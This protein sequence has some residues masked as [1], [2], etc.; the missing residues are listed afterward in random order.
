MISVKKFISWQRGIKTPYEKVSRGY[1]F[2]NCSEIKGAYQGYEK[3]KNGN[4][5]YLIE[6]R[7]RGWIGINERPE[8]RNKRETLEIGKEYY[9]QFKDGIVHITAEKAAEQS[10]KQTKFVKEDKPF[11]LSLLQIIHTSSS[12][13]SIR[14]H[15]NQ[16]DIS[17]GSFD[18]KEYAEEHVK[19]LKRVENPADYI[20]TNYNNGR[21]KSSKLNMI[22]KN[23][24]GEE[25]AEQLKILSDELIHYSFEEHVKLRKQHRKNTIAAHKQ[26]SAEPETEPEPE[27]EAEAEQVLINDGIK[28]DKVFHIV[29]QLISLLQLAEDYKLLNHDD[30]AVIIEKIYKNSFEQVTGVRV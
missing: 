8:I 18:K 15:Y 17:F 12:G 5:V 3:N 7:N 28:Q 9:F 1:T 23:Y 25:R 14:L 27:A 11:Y 22:Y 4:F 13:Y 21:R 2:L 29:R 10:T 20:L 6:T 24:T 26:Q 19:F 16:V 30:R